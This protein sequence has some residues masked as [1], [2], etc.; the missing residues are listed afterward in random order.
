LVELKEREASQTKQTAE[1]ERAG[2]VE[3][4]KKI[5]DER[6]ALAAERER[7]AAEERRLTEAEKATTEKTKSETATATAVVSG[8]EE[9]PENVVTKPE[10]DKD[11]AAGTQELATQ[12]Q[13]LEQKES[14]LA[15]KEK[16]LEEKKEAVAEAEAFVATKEAEA[17]EERADIAKDQQEIIEK[18]DAEAAA[19]KAPDGEFALRMIDPDSPFARLTVIDPASGKELKASVLDT[20][21][22]RSLLYLGDRIVA[23]AGKAEGA[24]AVRLVILDRDSLEM[25]AQGE[26]DIQ[27]QSPIWLQGEDLYAIVNSG[28][29]LRLGRF[30][31]DLKRIALSSVEVHSWASPTFPENLVVIQKADGSVIMLSATDLS[32]K[33]TSR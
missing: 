2:I 33:V 5:S 1:L 4:E 14:A 6:A 3:E 26:D 27:D 8:T 9:K 31:Q 29:G 25:A 11:V 32:E 12:K 20:I 13:E 7:L 24:G 17:A 30:D 18:Q 23:V 21:H 19:G 28:D 16:A 10:P 15:E 22:A